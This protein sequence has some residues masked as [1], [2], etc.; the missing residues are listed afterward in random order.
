LLPVWNTQIRRTTVDGGRASLASPVMKTRP[1]GSWSWLRFA[2]PSH[3]APSLDPGW[4]KCG[5]EEGVAGTIARC[6]SLTGLVPLSMHKPCGG[7][8]VSSVS[9][10]AEACRH[11]SRPRATCTATG[12]RF[13]R[14]LLTIPIARRWVKFYRVRIAVQMHASLSPCPP[15]PCNPAVPQCRASSPPPCCSPCP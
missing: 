14:N 4:N 6:R 7:T 8:A 2:V 9:H 5:R 13:T 12:S 15:R 10:L 1:T 3:I 11:T